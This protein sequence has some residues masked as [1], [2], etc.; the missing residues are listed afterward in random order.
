MKN[1]MTN[2]NRLFTWTLF[3]AFGAFGTC[4]ATAADEMTAFKLVKEGNQ[5]VGAD[6]KDRVVQ[7]RSEKS[8]G[9]VTPNVWWIVYYDP[10]AT[11]KAMEVK[12]VGGKKQSV[13]RPLR[14]LEPISGG[15]VEMD[16]QKLKT[17]SDQVIKIILKEQA[18]QNVKITATEMKLQHASEGFLGVAQTGDPVWMV[19]IWASKA[20]Q[21]G[22]DTE[23][24]E[25]FVA[26]ADG[27]VLKSDLHL[28]R[29]D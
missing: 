8:E 10:D 17:D 18:L 22:R 28:N 29:L 14:L 6:A 12:F 21:L 27:K 23:I 25:V 3:L 26:A 7:I 4:V 16:K 13:K 11:L 2:P 20:P 19:K 15:D 5:Y 1:L 9:S 24:G